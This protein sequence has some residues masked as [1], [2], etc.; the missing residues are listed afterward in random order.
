MPAA[1]P[2]GSRLTR[3]NAA[4]S[5]ATA[6]N[7]ILAGRTPDQILGPFFPVGQQPDTSGD[8]TH[9]G[10]AEGRILYLSGRLTTLA[11]APVAGARI[12]IWQANA[13]GKYLH[14]NDDNPA[15]VDPNFQ[16][17]AVLTSGA[18]GG[19]RLKTVCPKAYPTSPTTVR[20]AHIHFRITGRREQFVTQ[21]YFKGD[22]WND[23][24]P[25]LQ[26]ARRKEALIIDPQPAPPPAEPGA[27]Q[28]RFDIVLVSG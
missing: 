13:H 5:E 12:E 14:P 26:S 28:A 1:A 9:G 8:L 19:Y 2:R 23:S 7:P 20:P 17:F 6:L 16:G 4:V 22:P 24:D 15:P 3:R 21:L 25:F 27:V 10:R 11:G 18:D